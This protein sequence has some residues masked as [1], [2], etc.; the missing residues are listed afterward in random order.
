[1]TTLDIGRLRRVAYYAFSAYVDRQDPTVLVMMT[2]S[3]VDAIIESEVNDLPTAFQVLGTC[4][5][6]TVKIENAPPPVDP[7]F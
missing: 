6:A 4:L 5:D 7:D 2:D 3:L 1:M